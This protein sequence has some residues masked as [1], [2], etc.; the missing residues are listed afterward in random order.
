MWQERPN[1]DDGVREACDHERAVVRDIDS[2]DTAGDIHETESEYVKR[3]EIVLPNTP[4]LY[5][6]MLGM[7]S[8]PRL[9]LL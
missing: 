7:L 6:Q 3:K 5:M 4:Y 9:A 1:L 2:S 8:G